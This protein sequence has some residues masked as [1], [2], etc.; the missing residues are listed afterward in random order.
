MQLLQKHS[1]FSLNKLGK[2]HKNITKIIVSRNYFVIISVRMVSSVVLESE[3]VREIQT[4]PNSHLPARDAPKDQNKHVQI[5]APKP[6]STSSEQEQTYT[7]RTRSWKTL[8][9]RTYSWR[10]VHIRVALEPAENGSGP[11]FQTP[12]PILD[13][14][15]GP[16]DAR[17]LS[18]VGL[19]FGTHIGRTQL[20]PTPALDKNRHP[21]LAKWRGNRWHVCRANFARNICFGALNFLT[22]NASKISPKFF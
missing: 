19:G 8:Q 18:S 15:P 5:R 20:F 2:D 17:F 10:G 4:R 3:N 1:A 14:I 16:M 11:F 9:W 12:T 6:S 13:K 21:K 22:K 7:I